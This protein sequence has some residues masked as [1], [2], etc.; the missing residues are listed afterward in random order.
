MDVLVVRSQYLKV[1][2]RN[3]TGLPEFKSQKQK[4]KN[5][6]QKSCYADVYKK[7]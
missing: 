2:I 5:Q 3:P 6:K 1:P 4:K 7:D